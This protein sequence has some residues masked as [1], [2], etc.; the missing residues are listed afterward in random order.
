MA[1]PV[2]TAIGR[3]Q[4]LFKGTW[5]SITSYEKLDNVIYNGSTFIALKN[6]P[7]GIS[8]ENASYWQMIASKGDS[9]KGDTG[10][11]GAPTAS[12]HGLTYGED[13]TVVITATGPDDA[14]IFDFNF[15]LPAGPVGFDEV[16]ASASALPAGSSPSAT[17][18]LVSSGNDTTLQFTFGIPSADGSGAQAV[19]GVT[20]SLDV[21]TGLQNIQL[22]AV[23]A[24]QNQGLSELQKQYARQNINAQVA[25]NY[26]PAGNYITDPGASTGQFLRF[27]NEGEWVGE[28]I[29]LVPTGSASDTGKY[30]RRSANGMIWAEVQSLPAGGLEGAPLV[31]NSIDN[32]DVTWGSF[33]S[34]EEIDEIISAS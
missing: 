1:N 14:K 10:S 33:I 5:D 17:A 34:E 30:L 23:R 26:Q 4:P 9:I 19:D 29:N 20:P 3:V 6:V 28:N 27:S 31:K 16:A 25:G 18:Q 24:V 13:P 7:A 15:G 21:T 8:P 11:F 2:V 22:S 32:Y 12:A